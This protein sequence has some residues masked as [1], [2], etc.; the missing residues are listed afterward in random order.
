MSY[1][2]APEAYCAYREV[3]T[4]RYKQMSICRQVYTNVVIDMYIYI[5]YY[6]LLCIQ[7]SAY[8]QVQTNEYLQTDVHRCGYRHVHVDRCLQVVRC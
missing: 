4:D 2:I 5:I 8:G 7:R 1:D 3:L 6:S